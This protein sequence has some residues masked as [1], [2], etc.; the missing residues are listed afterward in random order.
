MSSE[1][2]FKFSP[3]LNAGQNVHSAWKIHVPPHVAV[4]DKL[5]TNEKDSHARVGQV[6]L[7]KCVAVADG[8]D[9][10][11]PKEKENNTDEQEQRRRNIGRE[12]A[13]DVELLT[14]SENGRSPDIFGDALENL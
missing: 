13:E 9:T 14:K 8:W 7:S 12:G 2:G 11:E 5:V 6:A 10:D 3:A 4:L 1:R